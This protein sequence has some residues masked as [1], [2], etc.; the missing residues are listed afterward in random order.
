MP[1]HRLLPVLLIIL[2]MAMHAAPADENWANLCARCHGAS[3]NGH[4]KVGEARFVKDYTD[5]KV[6]SHFTDAGLLKNLLLGITSEDGK[7]RMPS[8]KNKLAVTEAKELVALI[9][10]FKK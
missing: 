4:T 5:A 1:C 7:E 9:R 2:P 3:G 6:Q 10:T 8:F